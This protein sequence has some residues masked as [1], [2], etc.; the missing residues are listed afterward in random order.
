MTNHE[1]KTVAETARAQ[2]GTMN[3]MACGAREFSYDSDGTLKFKV[4]GRMRWVTVALDPSDTYTVKLVRVTRNYDLVT[5]EEHS[6]V[7]CDQLGETVYRAV[8]K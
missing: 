4:G 7:Y 6:G 3:L 2:I 1:A 8:N 5:V